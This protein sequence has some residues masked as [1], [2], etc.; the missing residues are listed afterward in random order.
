MKLKI[1]FFFDTSPNAGGATSEAIYMLSKLE[2]LLENKFELT[3]ILTSKKMKDL[4]LK[5]KSKIKFFRMNA[6]QRQICYLRNF[7]ILIKIR[8]FFFKNIFE[9][10]LKENKIDIVYF[11]NPSQYSL[12]IE[13]TD[14]II[15]VPDVSHRE[16]IE[17]PEW[18][19]ST[20]FFWKEEILSKSLI[21]AIS[22]ITNAEIIKNKIVSFY[23]VESDR[24][25]VIS[26]QPSDNI[27]NFDLNISKPKNNYNLPN[28][29]IFYPANFLPHKNHK[30]V[31]DVI[32]IL[33]NKKKFKISAVFCGSDKGYLKKIKEY[34]SRLDLNDEIIFLDYVHENDIPFLYLKSQA[35]IMPTF[36]GPT[37]IP[38]WEAFKM[39]VPVIYSNIFS[40]KEVYGDAVAYIDPFDPETGAEKTL[41]IY[42]NIKLKKD[43]IDNGKKLLKTNDFNKDIKKII[44]IFNKNKKIKQ[45]WKFI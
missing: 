14:F 16:N 23:S 39:E 10:F 26:H 30:Y 42:N 8:N 1:A 5:N 45:S 7:S 29:Y 20:N 9:S 25:Q 4:F 24:V 19:K 40:I 18:A 37:N 22:V 15:T 33:K 3:I 6:V 35:L 17:F 28:K 11:I 41:E 44:D 43:L 13:D 38:P 12:Y 27:T 21:R 36:S 31:I 2:E 32:N 34:V